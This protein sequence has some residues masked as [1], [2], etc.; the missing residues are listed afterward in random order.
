MQDEGSPRMSANSERAKLG[1]EVQSPLTTALP[2][3]LPFLFAHVRAD[4]PEHL[5]EQRQV[6][7]STPSGVIAWKWSTT[8]GL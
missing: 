8:P 7:A 5:L 6:E 1:S 4:F 2:V 3:V